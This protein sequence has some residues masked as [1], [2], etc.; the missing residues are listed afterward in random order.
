M[1]HR[2][3]FVRTVA[4]VGLLFPLLS[5]DSYPERGSPVEDIS[6]K[7]LTDAMPVRTRLGDRLAG[8]LAEYE[9]HFEPHRIFMSLDIQRYMKGEHLA[10]K[11]SFTG[12]TVRLSYG[13]QREADFPVF[14]VLKAAP[15]EATL[16]LE[17]T[18]PAIKA[19]R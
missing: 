5:C 10:L 12:D 16:D 15:P 4:L 7:V 8:Y 3:M 9:A 6:V 11:G 13:D 18:L 19:P 1:T 14:H 17:K 2:Q